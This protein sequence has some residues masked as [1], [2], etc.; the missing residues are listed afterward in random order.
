[1]GQPIIVTEKPSI[2][3]PGMVR[4]ETNR[5]LTGMGHER[6]ANRAAAVGERPPDELARRLFDHGGVE[7]VHINGNMITV[8]L[9][10]GR[11]SEGLAQVVHDLYLFYPGTDSVVAAAPTVGADT[12]ALD[13]AE[14][15]PAERAPRLPN[16]LASTA[17]VF[18]ILGLTILPGLGALVAIISGIAGLSQIKRG[19]AEG[20]TMATVGLLLGLVGAIAVTVAIVVIATR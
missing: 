13:A 10:K 15:A 19:K 2:A 5:A 7:T 11:S 4:F 16:G 9:E 14:V 1:M 17:L 18:G 3:H 12:H 6:Y 8:D 20:K